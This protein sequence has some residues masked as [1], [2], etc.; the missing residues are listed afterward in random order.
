MMRVSSKKVNFLNKFKNMIRKFTWVF[1][2]KKITNL[3]I[4]LKKSGF[5]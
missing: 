1:Y 2:L 4:S 5:K 3:N